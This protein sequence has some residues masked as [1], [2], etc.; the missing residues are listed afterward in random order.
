MK[1]IEKL[2]GLLLILTVFVSCK[3]SNSEWG[4]SNVMFAK[5]HSQI[6]LYD[7]DITSAE[8]AS[9][10]D[11]VVNFTG[12]YRSGLVDKLEQIT[13]NL[14]VDG[15]YLQNVIDQ[16]A[17]LDVMEQSDLMKRYVNS[18]VMPASMVEIP[19]QVVIPAGDRKVSLP[20]TLKLSQL[21]LYDNQYLNYSESDYLNA[22]V[23][24]DRKLVLCVKITNASSCEVLED[25]RYCYLEIVKC[26][27]NL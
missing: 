11:S 16:A 3:D 9:Q 22:S 1:S 25:N 12:V 20:V 26:L 2:I 19:N 13:V 15:A 21:K 14:E 4:N 23:S 10:S 18:V 6:D 27:P 7:T 17:V 5:V 24:K 8:V